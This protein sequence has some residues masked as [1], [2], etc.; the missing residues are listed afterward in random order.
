MSSIN[1]VPFANFTRDLT[2]TEI[3][4]V[5]VDS[6][7]RTNVDRV[8]T[9]NDYVLG[10]FVGEFEKAF[11][12]YC[13]V[14]HCV[15]VG[16]GLSALEL[17]LRALDVGLDDEV[18]TVANT[19]NA[20]VA[21]IAKVG[22]K[23]VLVEPS[24][25]DFNMD[26]GAVKS[27][28]T[29]KTKVVLPVHLYG[30]TVDMDDLLALAAEHNLLVLEDACQSHGSLYAGR[31]AGSFGNAGC[32]SFYPGKNLGGIGD[33]G[34]IITDDDSLASKLRK[35]R[36]YGQT[37]KYLHDELP[38]NSRLDTIQAAALLEKLKVL[39]K[40]NGMRA[41]NAEVYREE[42]SSLAEVGLP[43]ERARG[44]H[45]YH[46]FVIRTGQRDPLADYLAARGIQSGVHY[47]VP[48]H[49]QPCFEDLGYVKGDFPLSEQICD[50]I[51]TL[52]MFP[53]LR[54]EEIKY[55]AACMKDF[56]ARR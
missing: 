33:G 20:T 7:I 9:K 1:N 55:V 40:W 3:D 48:I 39:D 23:T 14:K 18:I 15:G 30:Q 5:T 43:T 13:G 29:A 31:R 41:D 28:I 46:L 17:S 16:S 37:K 42:L 11:A 49:L 24:Q 32:F 53:T 22:A 8:L 34:A 6:L 19:F 35:I 54:R 12:G 56:F 36:N 25:R 38:D 26:I 10:G 51:L 47:P 52:P 27:A 50:T 44:E 4:G 45:I 21:A 2:E